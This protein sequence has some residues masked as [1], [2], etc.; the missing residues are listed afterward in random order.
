MIRV[1]VPLPPPTYETQ[2]RVPGQAFLT[3]NPAPTRTDWQR[4]R[5]WRHIHSDLYEQVHGICSYCASFT[6]RRRSPASV[7]HTSIDHFVP[8]SR[9]SA[10]AYEWANF[11]LCRA[12]LNN[13]KADFDDVLD[14]YM[15]QDGWFRLSFMTFALSPN[16]TLPEERQREVRNSIARLELNSDDSYVNERARVIYSYADSKLSFAELTKRYPFIAAELASQDFD[17]VYLPHFKL[18]LANPRSRGA[19]IRQG[20]MV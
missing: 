18:V 17:L 9:N 12:R 6:P 5:Y 16:P 7:D 11:R 10:L 2:V 3:A 13:R 4:H 8:K 14:P 15:I 19:L 1:Q 20:L